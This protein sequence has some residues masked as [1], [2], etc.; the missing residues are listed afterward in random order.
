MI[1]SGDQFF[2]VGLFEIYGLDRS[3]L[4]A[5]HAIDAATIVAPGLVRAVFQFGGDPVGVFDDGAIHIDDVE[6]TVGAVGKIDGA[7]PF[8]ASGEEF[9]L[10]RLGEGFE[11]DAGGVDL[12]AVDEISGGIAGERVACETLRQSGPLI[13]EDTTGG[14]ELS[15]VEIGSGPSATER[16]DVRGFAG[17]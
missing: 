9:T 10:G 11:G 5:F 4:F 7:E 12:I 8:I 2:G 3:G 6:G 15:G 14:G 13:I 17:G 1:Q 16:V